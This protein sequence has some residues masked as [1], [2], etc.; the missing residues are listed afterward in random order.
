ME[1][2]VDNSRSDCPPQPRRI[3]G[4][5]C[6]VVYPT[7]YESL[8]LNALADLL[9][10]ELDVAQIRPLPWATC[11]LAVDNHFFDDSHAPAWEPDLWTLR[12]QP[13]ERLGVR[14]HVRAWTRSKKH[15]KGLVRCL[16][17]LQIW[18]KFLVS[19]KS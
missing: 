18:L 2:K 10:V 12:I 16:R 11:L 15:S 1:R 6:A 13:Q 8:S 14:T 5:G 17:W 7:C 4:Q 19:T 3:G 9:A